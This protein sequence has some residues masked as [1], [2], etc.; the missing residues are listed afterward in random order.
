MLIPRLHTFLAERGT[1]LEPIGRRNV[2]GEGGLGAPRSWAV[3]TVD[4]GIPKTGW[5]ALEDGV[6]EFQSSASQQTS[7]SPCP[8][9]KEK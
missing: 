3:S 6:H 7:F 8:G 1:H 9:V 5:L 4:E 2:E